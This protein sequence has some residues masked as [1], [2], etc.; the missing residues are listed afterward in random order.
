MVFCSC[1]PIRDEGACKRLLR[2]VR[3]AR[4][5]HKDKH[6]RNPKR[7]I[8]H[9]HHDDLNKRKK[10]TQTTS[11]SYPQ[12]HLFLCFKKAQTVTTQFH[13]WPK[14]LRQGRS[15]HMSS[16]IQLFS[17]FLHQQIER[18]IQSPCDTS[19]TVR[20]ILQSRF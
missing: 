2:W 1:A 19:S 13:T 14:H 16:K 10:T 12:C 3:Q 7:S 17:C 8:F 15:N 4:E 11:A 5:P 6:G 9:H 18:R 20:P